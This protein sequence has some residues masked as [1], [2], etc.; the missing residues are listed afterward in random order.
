MD[1]RFNNWQGW[2]QTQAVALEHLERRTGQTE[3]QWL[4][5]LATTRHG[6]DRL[7][8]RAL[9]WV[10]RNLVR[11]GWRLQQRYGAAGTIP[12]FYP[13]KTTH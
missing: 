1:P 5:P 13:A 3:E 12:T 6:Y 4:A 2:F 10:G 8:R 7:R 9:G 11:W